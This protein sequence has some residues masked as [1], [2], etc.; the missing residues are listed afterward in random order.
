MAIGRK[1]PVMT[2]IFILVGGILLWAV[3]V[4]VLDGIN[5]RR[6]QREHK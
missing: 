4:T 2:G 6:K 5:F 3:T 1:D